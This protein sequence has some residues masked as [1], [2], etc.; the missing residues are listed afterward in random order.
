M[1]VEEVATIVDWARD[2]GWNP[3]MHDAEIF[4]AADPDGLFCAEMEGKIVG[5][6]SA[7]AYDDTYGFVGL[8]IVRPELRGHR[9]GLDLAARALERLGNR[10]IGIDGVLAKEGQYTKFYGF[11]PAGRNVRFEGRPEGRVTPGLVDARSLPFPDL[12]AYDRR[13]FPSL[14]EGFL[15]DWIH[16]EGATALADTRG[17]VL[18]GYGVIR[19]CAVGAKVGP[20]FAESPA[21]AEELFLALCARVP[22]GLVYLD[23]PGDNPRAV[24]LARK[25]ALREVF[26]TTRMYRGGVPE[27]NREGVF[28]VTTFELG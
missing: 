23:T 13:H 5:G 26:A 6:I 8:F 20:L 7:V 9:V 4:A 24:E 27:F 3:G 15:R 1:K 2:E 28:G 10:I 14:R 25:F 12:S 17:G 18:R 22:E 21:V 16:Q 11:V 19:P